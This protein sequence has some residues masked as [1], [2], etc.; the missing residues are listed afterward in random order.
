MIATLASSVLKPSCMA[1]I[2]AAIKRGLLQYLYDGVRLGNLADTLGLQDATIDTLEDA[3][4]FFQQFIAKDI[5][6][7][8]ISVGS[9]GMGHQV[10]FAAIPIFRS[11]EPSEL[12]AAVQEMREI[13]NDALITL[14]SGH[15]VIHTNDAQIL[16]IMMADDR[17][18]TV[19]RTQTDWTLTRLPWVRLS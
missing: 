11:Y 17:M 14:A 16:S 7:G 10:Q 18:Q 9:S 19:T 8:K 12:F 3:L 4:M 15:S 2:K 6:S 13:Y 1:N 5:Q